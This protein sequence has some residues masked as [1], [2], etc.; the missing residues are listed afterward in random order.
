MG[1]A[2]IAVLLAFAGQAREEVVVRGVRLPAGD[3]SERLRASE[4]VPPLPLQGRFPAWTDRSEQGFGGE[5]V[6]RRWV[7]LLRAERSAS[8]PERRAELTLL[9]RLQ[10]RDADAWNHLAACAAE[11]GLVS[12]LLPLFSPGVA[13]EELGAVGPLPDGALLSPAL[14]P[15]VDARAAL[16]FLAGKEVECQEFALGAAR[17]ALTVAVDRDGLEVKLV[18]RS[19]GP[20]RVR[21]VPPLPRG[22]DAGLL[23]AD[24][25]KRPGHAG[26]LEFALTPEE[27][28]H[29]LWLTFHAPE[30]RW[31][32]PLPETLVPL[33]PGRMI[34]LIGERGDEPHLMRFAEA[35]EELFG[36]RARLQAPG[37]APT[38]ALEPLVLRFDSPAAAERKLVELFGLAE[39]FA[40]HG[41]VR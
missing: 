10:G 1:H 39:A 8:A 35:L 9:A 38:E 34:Q 32:L 4:G 13:A 18:H 28:E 20:A 6:W 11:P 40:L 14:P 7:E 31:P 23:F 25:E 5:L 33:A 15:S 12:A 36:S 22:V 27:P 2:T 37:T 30:E 24:W 41:P 21:V 26:P 29:S 3:V 16:R 19:G 17:I